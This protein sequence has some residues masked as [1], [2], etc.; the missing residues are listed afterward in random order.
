MCEDVPRW[1]ASSRTVMR[2]RPNPGA[3]KPVTRKSRPLTVADPRS[4]SGSSAGIEE[5][6]TVRAPRTCTSSVVRRRASLTKFAGVTTAVVSDPMFLPPASMSVVRAGA[7]PCGEPVWSVTPLLRA[8]TVRTALSS[9]FS[10]VMRWSSFTRSFA[11][12]ACVN[13]RSRAMRSPMSCARRC[14]A[15][16]KFEAVRW[17]C[18]R[19]A[20][21]LPF[22]ESET[23]V[24]STMATATIGTITMVTKNSVRRER[25]LMVGCGAGRR[26]V[27]THQREVSRKVTPPELQSASRGPGTSPAGPQEGL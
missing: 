23:T 20:S 10:A 22:S 7:T 11:A 9:A 1:S 12:S 5:A 18:D 16:K 3:S 8:S 27:V 13:P 25:K 24:K 15:W 21:L 2:S 19:R 17:A 6:R 26:L 4:G 14:R